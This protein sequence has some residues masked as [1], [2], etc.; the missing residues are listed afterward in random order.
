MGCG[1]NRSMPSGLARNGALALP[2]EEEV[3]FVPV[4]ATSGD[5]PSATAAPTRAESSRSSLPAP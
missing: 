3:G 4:I 1:R 2:A 5:M